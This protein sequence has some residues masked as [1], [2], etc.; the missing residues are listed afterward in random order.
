MSGGN[1]STRRAAVLALLAPWGLAG[2]RPPIT[3]LQ[4]IPMFTCGSTMPGSLSS[5]CGKSARKRR[6]RR[7][8]VGELTLREGKVVWDLNGITSKDW[9]DEAK[10]H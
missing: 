1:R 4:L 8:L 9:N 5:G 10:K 6:H 3:T 7:K 2:S